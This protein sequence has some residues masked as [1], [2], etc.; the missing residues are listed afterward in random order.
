M[1]V[2]VGSVLA[3]L[4][5]LFALVLVGHSRLPALPGHLTSLA[6]TLLPW[7]ALAIPVFAALA[8]L[9]RSRTATA[10]LVLPVAAWLTVYGGTLGDKSSAGGDLTLVSHNVSQ[11]NPDPRATARTLIASG[12]DV[13][14]LQ[15][16]SPET[17]PAYEAALA[18]AYPHHFQQGTVGLWST[19]PLRDARAVP[20]MPW[21]RAM[22]ATVDTAHGPLAVH[23]VHL[24][25]VRVGPSGFTAGARDDVITVVEGV[26]RAERIPRV[27]LM[28]DF[29]GSTDDRAFRPLTSRMT[30]AQSSAGAGFGFTWPAGFPVVR[31]DQILVAGVR[32]TGAWT[33][34]ATPSDHLPVA[35]R[36][37]LGPGEQDRA[38]GTRGAG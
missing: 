37:S 32:A 25:S 31:I 26:L 23:V 22:R 17:A 20:I 1:P 7:S 24:P 34:P 5:A 2:P 28:G 15:E 19:L 29:N 16:L 13:I 14:A 21:T 38:D 30:S 27:V 11:D 33:L 4:S 9:R 6:E 3:V 36:V 18:D 12:A 10:A 8:L 35:A